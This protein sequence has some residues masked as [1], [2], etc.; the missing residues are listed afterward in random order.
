MAVFGS[1]LLDFSTKHAVNFFSVET[2]AYMM[3]PLL[4]CNSFLVYYRHH[5]GFRVIFLAA[6]QFLKFLAAG[7]QQIERQIFQVLSFIQPI[8]LYF[9]QSDSTH[10]KI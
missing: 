8:Y 5:D 10:C 7:L 1:I 9:F 6:M 4:N 3:L 2:G